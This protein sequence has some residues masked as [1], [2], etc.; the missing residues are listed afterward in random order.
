M[1]C[2]TQKS[3]KPRGEKQ[4]CFLVYSCWIK[5][6]KDTYTQTYYALL[7]SPAMENTPHIF[8][9]LPL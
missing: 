3:I 4:G 8:R 1:R 2:V 6:N 7:H 9:F 5:S